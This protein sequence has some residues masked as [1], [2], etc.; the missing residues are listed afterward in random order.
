M[1]KPLPVLRVRFDDAVQTWL[2][3]TASPGQILKIET[4][5]R[6]NRWGYYGLHG[7]DFAFLYRHRP[8]WD[9]VVVALL[10]GVGVSSVTSIVPA[11][12]RLAR[13]AR[14]LALLAR[15]QV[16]AKPLAARHSRSGADA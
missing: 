14:K 10:V 2:Y 3:V 9:V 16:S 8:V 12:R 5:D 13:H 11:I 7:F 15:P 6:A 4:Q 1:A